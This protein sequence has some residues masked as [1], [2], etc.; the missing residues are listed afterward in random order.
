MKTEASDT[1]L[2]QPHNLLGAGRDRMTMFGDNIAMTGSGYRCCCRF[3]PSTRQ[4]PKF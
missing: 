4:R 2:V 3:Y 1:I